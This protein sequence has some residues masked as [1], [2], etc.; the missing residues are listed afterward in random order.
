MFDRN[1]MSI[2]DM[3]SVAG[4]QPVSNLLAIVAGQHLGALTESRTDTGKRVAG[5]D[6][7]IE[8]AAYEPMGNRRAPCT[9]RWSHGH[10]RGRC[11][12]R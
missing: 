5:R 1:D 6:D 7:E 12:I 3:N 9:G 2:V 8:F 11:W 10:G 4:I